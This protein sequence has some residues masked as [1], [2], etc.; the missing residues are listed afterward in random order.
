MIEKH[1]AATGG[2]ADDIGKSLVELFAISTPW[3]L[4]S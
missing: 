2:V 1:L 4:K 3:L